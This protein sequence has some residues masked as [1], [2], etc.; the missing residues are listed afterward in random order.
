MEEDLPL[1][2]DLPDLRQR[3]HHPDLVVDRHHRHE[4]RLGSDGVLQELEVDQPVL[5]DGEIRHV[6]ALQRGRN[7]VMSER[8]IGAS[9]ESHCDWLVLTKLYVLYVCGP[10]LLDGKVRR[11]EALAKRRERSRKEMSSRRLNRVSM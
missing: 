2:A 6:E 1:P 4:H 11:V 9:R 10:D 8:P 7:D 3:L 5:L